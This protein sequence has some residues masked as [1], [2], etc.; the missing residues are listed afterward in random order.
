MD[1]FRDDWSGRC[2]SRRSLIS[3]ELTVGGGII[4]ADYYILSL[5]CKE[6]CAMPSTT[7]PQ[8]AR[9]PARE[10]RIRGVQVFHWDTT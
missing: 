2:E 1:V 8:D 9:A 5:E 10:T 3:I 4:R 7:H 6:Q